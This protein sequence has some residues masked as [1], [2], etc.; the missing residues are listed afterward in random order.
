MLTFLTQFGL[1]QLLVLTNCILVAFNI[2]LLGTLFSW[3]KPRAAAQPKPP[4]PCYSKALEM[5]SSEQGDWYVEK[6]LSC[7]LAKILEFN[8]RGLGSAS[9]DDCEDLSDDSDDSFAAD[10]SD[11]SDE[12]KNSETLSGR[13]VLID[14]DSPQ[15]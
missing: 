7:E 9:D 6:I 14:P 5:L 15:T 4:K 3:I 2:L 1:C 13:A 10:E 11:E 12:I 8:S